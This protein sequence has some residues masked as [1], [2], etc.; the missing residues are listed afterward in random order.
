MKYY[1]G[2]ISSADESIA[3]TFADEWTLWEMTLCS[4]RYD[5]EKLK[6]D[7]LGDKDNI[8]VARL[9]THYFLHACFVPENYILDNISKIKHIPCS[10]VQ[11][12]FDMCTPPISAVDLKE[13][14][15]ENLSLSIVNSGHLSSDPE[16]MV[17]L[18]TIAKD[19]LV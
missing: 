16:M 17:V 6:L 1:A 19:L 5:P 14:Y 7:T 18:R 2:M 15:G 12:R 8:A 4:I 13:A 10:L 3:R 11:G 9:E